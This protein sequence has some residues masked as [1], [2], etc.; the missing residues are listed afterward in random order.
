VREQEERVR[1]TKVNYG[2][3]IRDRGGGVGS[4]GVHYEQTVRR[5]GEEGGR[6]GGNLTDTAY[7]AGWGGR[8]GRND[9]DRF[10]VG[11]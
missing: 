4:A 2:Q 10:S 3:P 11:F 9:G 7:E 1:H 8:T 6:G 5:G